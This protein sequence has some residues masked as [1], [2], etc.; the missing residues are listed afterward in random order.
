MWSRCQL[1][2]A[3]E[4]SRRACT[5]T[6]WLRPARWCRRQ[7][8]EDSSRWVGEGMRH[9]VGPNGAVFGDW[10]TWFVRG[11]FTLMDTQT[12]EKSRYRRGDILT[13][14]EHSGEPDAIRASENQVMMSGKS[15]SLFSY[16]E[17]IGVSR[18]KRTFDAR[19]RLKPPSPDSYPTLHDEEAPSRT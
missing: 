16:L 1:R 12:I 6:P 7:G 4:V 19:N 5:P 11:L 13:E 17:R 3:F 2:F 9:H 8:G 15:R 14:Q 18:L 10:G